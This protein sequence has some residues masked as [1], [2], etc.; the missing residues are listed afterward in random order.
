MLE[1]VTPF[2]IAVGGALV[3]F[4]ADACRR[5]TVRRQRILGHRTGLT[6]RDPKARI[7][8]HRP[9]APLFYIAGGWAA[10]AGLAGGV[11]VRLG[12]T[13]AAV[14]LGG[15]IA[16]LLLWTTLPGLPGAAAAR[17]YRGVGDQVTAEHSPR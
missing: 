1:L 10:L 4:H 6:M 16:W 11:L 9:M 8:V 13:A 15:A 5:G 14:V 3:V 7:A 17:D 2:L 12:I